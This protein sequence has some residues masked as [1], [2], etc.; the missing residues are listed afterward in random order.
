VNDWMWLEIFLH[1]DNAGGKDRWARID[2][3][4]AKAACFQ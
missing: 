3:R 4:R 2:M 1:A